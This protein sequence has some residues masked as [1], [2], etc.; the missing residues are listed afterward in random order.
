MVLLHL[1]VCAARLPMLQGEVAEGKPEL[2][3]AQG[4]LSAFAGLL[5]VPWHQGGTQLRM[6]ARKT[7]Q[8]NA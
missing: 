5:P 4:Q 7:G 1:A 8:L 2:G 3:R 6:S